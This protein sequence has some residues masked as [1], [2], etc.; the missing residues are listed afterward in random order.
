ME[1]MLE[2]LP[3]QQ[4]LSRVCAESLAEREGQRSQ[5]AL[6]HLERDRKQQE[7][8]RSQRTGKGSNGKQ[9]EGQRSQGAPD[10]LGS[11]GHRT[12]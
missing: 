2:L 7:R 9:R 1:L 6:D 11:K 3:G 8:L 4:N 10:H 12:I 5:G